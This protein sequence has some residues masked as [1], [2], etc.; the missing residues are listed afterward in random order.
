MLKYLNLTQYA[1]SNVV[2]FL[3]GESV[4][5]DDPKLKVRQGNFS[6]EGFWACGYFVSTVVLRSQQQLTHFN[7]LI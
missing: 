1:A 3:K 2:R 6:G 4:I 7:I 5:S